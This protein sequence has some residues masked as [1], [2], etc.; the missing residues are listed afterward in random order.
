MSSN[1]DIIFARYGGNKEDGRE[2]SS[3]T[4]SLEFY[5]TK[6]HLDSF[7]KG[8]SRVLEMGCAT[9]H[10]GFYYADK[11]KEYVGI[12]LYPPHIELF[13]QRIR[14][15]KL[16]NISC[17]IGDATNL[18]NIPNDSFDVVLCLGPMY[19]LPSE[20]RELV[21][22][23]CHR[24]CK[25]EGIVAFAYINKIGV[26]AGA[27]VYDDWRHIYPNAKTNEYVLEKCTDDER[28]DL[29]HFTMPEEMDEM[30][31]RHGFTKVN[32]LGTNFMFTMKIVNDMTDERYELMKPLYDQMCTYE[33]CTGMAD[34]ALLICKK[35]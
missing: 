23:E 2:T 18:V 17:Q 3:R 14:D 12:D 29:F 13:S 15:K 34:H 11:C 26:Y 28:P 10:Y 22:T 30:A 5:Y 35:Q 20:E 31:G 19:H 25:A 27:C 6:K 1:Q 33:S 24:V 8:D 32:N 9:G 21:F 4:A 7:I 16:N